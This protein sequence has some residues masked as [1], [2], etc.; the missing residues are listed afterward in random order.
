M[1]FLLAMP[2]TVITHL[3]FYTVTFCTVVHSID[4]SYLYFIRKSDKNGNG[5]EQKNVEKEKEEL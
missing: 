3:A 4:Y 2:I 5:A 1:E